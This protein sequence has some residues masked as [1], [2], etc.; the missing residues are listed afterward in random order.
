MSSEVAIRCHG[1]GKAY[2][3]YAQP[4]DRLKQM[5]LGRHKKFYNEFWALHDLDLDVFRGE[6][7]GIIGRNGSGKS[8]LLQMICGTLTPTRGTLEVHGRI[9][10]LLELGAGFNPEFSGKENVFLN[11][12][13]LGLDRSEMERRYDSIVA[14]ADIG[15]HVDQ[16]VR[17]YSSGMHARLAFAVAINVDPEI[18]V[19][20]E[21]LAVGDEAFQRKCFG[22]IR[23]IRDA[24]ATVLFVS[25]SA[26]TV[27]SLCDRAILLDQGHRLLTG[28]AKTVVAKYQKL[29]FASADRIPEIRKEIQE[30]DRAR[31]AAKDAT[32]TS[33]DPAAEKTESTPVETDTE[34]FDS[35]LKPAS[36]IAYA[37]RG[38]KIEDVKITDLL[39]TPVNVLLS[40][41]TYRYTYSVSFTNEGFQVR[42]GMMIKTVLGVEV[43]GSASHP[44]G[45]GIEF[46][47]A[48]SQLKVSFEFTNLFTPGTYFLNAGVLGTTEDGP[49]WLDRLLDVAMFRVEPTRGAVATGI[50]N[51][52]SPSH[53][54][55]TQLNKP[56]EALSQV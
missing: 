33:Q 49:N 56:V 53:C 31:S 26:G 27:I 50:V 30:L 47:A 16:P 35:S 18:L 38:V 17:T 3:V 22:R 43:A 55:I 37:S 51:L 39:G 54:E 13:I 12:A 28:D 41:K 45:E 6:A 21:A 44:E 32:E 23:Q 9:A 48:G 15:E 52:M 46:V 25:H 11:G 42:F 5:F 24:G 29:A 8:T 36:T 34:Y 40:G 19:V 4:Q 14:F 20:D 10:A 1:L 2:R 7:I